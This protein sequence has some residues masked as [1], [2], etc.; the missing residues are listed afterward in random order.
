MKLEWLGHSAFRLT[1]STGSS[2]ITDPFDF[3]TVGYS[4]AY[5]NTD[6]VTIST[7]K[8]DHNNIKSVKSNPTIIDNIGTF[9][10][11]GI[12]IE[13]I[14]SNP[15]DNS[16]ELNIMYKFRLD[17]VTVCHLGNINKACTS[18][19]VE[20]LLPINI[21]LIPIGGQGHTI[22]A[23]QAKE[24]VDKIMPDIVIPMHYDTKDCDIEIDKLD[25]FL[26]LFD[27]EHIKEVDT[28][29]IEFDRYDFN[30]ESTTILV[31]KRFKG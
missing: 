15:D 5:L 7:N 10:L 31:P 4:M 25:S 21:L 18:D 11:N 9:D 8:K 29:H 17:G 12:N 6:G 26:K 24:Y 19:I 20:E 2:I 30:G 16:D 27:D 14:Y 28:K 13:G 22:D 23:E 3:K 1:E